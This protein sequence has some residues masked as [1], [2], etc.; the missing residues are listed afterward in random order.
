MP[1]TGE[2]GFDPRVLAAGMVVAVG[3]VLL[4]GLLPSIRAI[5]RSPGRLSTAR[6]DGVRMGRSRLRGMLVG[7]EIALAVVLLATTAL[8]LRS[9]TAIRNVDT[10]LR[11]QGVMAFT[12]NLPESRYPDDATL[13]HVVERV[14]E[15]LAAVPGVGSVGVGVGVPARRWRSVSYRLAEDAAGDDARSVFTRFATPGYLFT[16][17]VSVTRGR[18]LNAADGAA[19]GRVALVNERFARTHWPAAEPIGRVLQVGGEAVEVVGV[20]PDVHEY[21]PTLPPQPGIYLPLAQWPARQLDVVLDGADASTL[22]AD[23]RE[24][25][26]RVDPG[27]GV[28]GAD[29]LERI[30]MGPAEQFT[31]LGKLLAVLGA[32]ALLLAVVGVYG[33]MAYAVARRVPEIGVRMAL[34][35]EPATIRGM[36]LRDASTITV[37][38][39]VIGLLLALGA[40][41]GISAFLF[42]VRTSDPLI[43]AVV[44]A[45]LLGVSLAAAWLPARRASRV[46][47]LDALRSP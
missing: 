33:S 42:G 39:L 27:L 37:T 34:G 6:T 38:G 15:E 13:S 20:V 47:P 18:G 23:I 19:T 46:D 28:H 3:S 1:R 14:Q 10:G 35:A 22:L 32:A 25:V 5:A 9:V 17:G 8:V 29:T 36:V 7:A 45:L 4:F 2:I 43:F 24:A 21:G 26:A 12:L 31:A 30:L 40:A 44:G 41:R 16:L 11:T